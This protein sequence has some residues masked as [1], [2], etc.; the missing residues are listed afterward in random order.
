[1]GAVGRLHQ[2]PAA[3]HGF[4]NLVRRLHAHIIVLAL[5]D[6]TMNLR[7]NEVGG[8]ILHSMGQLGGRLFL[9]YFLKPELRFHLA[10]GRNKA[11]FLFDH[12]FLGDFGLRLIR[13]GLRFFHPFDGLFQ[14]RLGKIGV[15]KL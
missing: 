11:A 7:E 10:G 2:P 12:G 9:V 3:L 4:L 15:R 8:R 13:L 5:C 14:L 6:L 1:M